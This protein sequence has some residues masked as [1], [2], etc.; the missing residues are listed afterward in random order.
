MRREL[1]SVHAFNFIYH[2]HSQC[3]KCSTKIFRHFYRFA[4]NNVA[5]ITGKE[6]KK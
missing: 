4:Q 1:L 6:Q 2:S 5:H 3:S